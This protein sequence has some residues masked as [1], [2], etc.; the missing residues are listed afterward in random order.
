MLNST[1]IFLIGLLLLAFYIVSKFI[2]LLIRIIR[3]MGRTQVR[4]GH[5][6]YIRAVS[7]RCV[8]FQL[9]G[10]DR[11]Y[12]MI[13]NG[14]WVLFRGDKVRVAGHPDITGKFMVNAYNNNT[15]SIYGNARLVY[16]P[17]VIVIG[18]FYVMVGMVYINLYSYF[19]IA[20][21]V[22]VIGLINVQS[23]MAVRRAIHVLTK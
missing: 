23:D 19:P 11:I 13:S 22:H 6:K 1:Q 21:A 9:V 5:I 3:G 10:D 7:R 18:A 15:R 20:L 17:W 16:A 2:L 4:Q 8:Q 14:H 12:E